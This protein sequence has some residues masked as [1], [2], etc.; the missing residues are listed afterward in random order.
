M[1]KLLVKEKEIIVPGEI[2]AEGMDYLPGNGTYR[3]GEKIISN[4][5][6]LATIDGRAIKL[7]PL[8]G[9]YLPKVG[10]TIIGKVKDIVMSGWMLDTYSPYHAMLSMM[11]GSSDYIQKGADLTK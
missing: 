8:T 7:I 1:T 11:N 2:L 6:G 9:K 4:R 10:D 5:L 3:D